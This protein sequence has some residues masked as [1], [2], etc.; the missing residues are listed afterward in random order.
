[1]RATGSDDVFIVKKVANTYYKRLILNPAIF[2]SYGHL[3]W[4]DVQDIN[5]SLLDK[6]Q[7]SNLVR[8]IDGGAVYALFPN[9]DTGIKRHLQVTPTQFEALGY[10]W[11]SIYNI[12]TKEAGS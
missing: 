4:S 10:D 5:K 8:H 1:M 9:G 3:R 7:T 11:N 12:N 2:E 6:L